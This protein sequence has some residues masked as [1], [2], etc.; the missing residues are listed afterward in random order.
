MITRHR[1]IGGLLAFGLVAFAPACS[2]TF[3]P[4]VDLDGDYRANG[5]RRAYAK[6]Y[7]GGLD[8]GR[9][10]AR[11]RRRVDYE[12]TAN[13]ATA[14]RDTTGATES[15]TSTA[16]RSAAGSPEVTPSPIERTRANVMTTATGA[17][18][19]SGSRPQA[20]GAVSPVAA[21]ISLAPSDSAFN[22]ACASAVSW[23]RCAASSRS[24][25]RWLSST[26]RRTSAS[27][28]SAVA[29]L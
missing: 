3:S 28:S 4:R 1:L 7:E 24:A 17:D 11:K 13:I 21:I 27:M 22:N 9:D 14:S 2:A 18:V 10:D 15:A 16:R 5:Q 12:D 23:L 19:G 20:T 26:M 6:G 25:S 8:K 29:S